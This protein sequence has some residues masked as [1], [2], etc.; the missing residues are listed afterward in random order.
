MTAATKKSKRVVP[1]KP[2][3]RSENMRRIRSENTRPELLLRCELHRRGLRYRIHVASLP[4]K[5]D[6]VFKRQRLAV[7]VHGC[8]WHQHS[9]CLEASKPHSN[10]EYWRP[11]L[12]RNVQRDR[13]HVQK[14]RLMQYRVLTLWE[15]G[16]ENGPKVA[17]EEVVRALHRQEVSAK[18]KSDPRAIPDS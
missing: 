4:G 16:V 10:Q 8:F 11:K 2:V 18:K 9:G 12:L 17:A 14:L 6:I 7:F 3:G 1:E 5:P 13:E 15:C